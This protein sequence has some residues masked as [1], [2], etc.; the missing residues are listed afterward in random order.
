LFAKKIT[1][2]PSSFH[3]YAVKEHN[4]TSNHYCYGFKLPIK[5]MAKAFP[6]EPS[7]WSKLQTKLK[8][9]KLLTTTAARKLTERDRKELSPADSEKR[10]TRS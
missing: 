9:N 3:G 10:Q 7:M 2:L 8:R 5:V 1:E 6:Q 4:V